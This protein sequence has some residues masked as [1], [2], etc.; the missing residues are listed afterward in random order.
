[1]T[2]AL[3]HRV[4]GPA[5][6]PVLVLLNSLGTDLG[7]WDPQAAALREEL[8][9]VRLDTRGHGASPLADAPWTL[10]DLGGDV[11]ALLDSLGIRKA[12]F[13]GVSLGG[14]TGYAINPAREGENLL[15]DL[16]AAF[17]ALLDR[18]NDFLLERGGEIV[19][20]ERRRH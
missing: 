7:M 16:R 17:R 9:L 4:E 19:A 1:M 13:A 6:A 8:R 5:E 18:L 20:Q 15:H 12:S 3:N 2:V 11:L 14:A 10:A